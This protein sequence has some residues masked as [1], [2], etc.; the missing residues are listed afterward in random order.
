MLIQSLPRSKWLWCV[1]VIALLLVLG[2]AKIG[3]TQTQF[4]PG[5]VGIGME[6]SSRGEQ[7]RVRGWT[8]FGEAGSVSSPGAI[9]FMPPDGTGFYHLDNAG[10]QRLRISGGS[11]PGQ[12]EYMT[13]SHPGRVTISGDLYIDGNLSVRGVTIGVT[14]LPPIEEILTPYSTASDIE[15]LNNEII[16]LKAKINET[17]ER[18]NLLSSKTQ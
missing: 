11:T 6:A 17:I 18:V 4:F 12:F 7:L 15:Y 8:I 3:F 2:L 10:N 16:R 1:L 5:R 14:G 9:T 13:I